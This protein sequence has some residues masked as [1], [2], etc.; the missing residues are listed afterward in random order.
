VNPEK[1][2]GPQ[3]LEERTKYP[4][5]QLAMKTN[6]DCKKVLCARA[7]KRACGPKHLRR[8]PRSNFHVLSAEGHTTTQRGEF[9]RMLAVHREIAPPWNS[10]KL[11][12]LPSQMV[13]SAGH[14]E[15][16]GLAKIR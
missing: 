13:G 15:L 11:V 9:R 8:I 2:A 5:D 16:Q 3:S 1:I 7:C 6:H 10:E 14:I 12:L 4:A